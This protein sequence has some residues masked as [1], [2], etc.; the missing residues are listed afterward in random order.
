[1]SIQSIQKEQ[2]KTLALLLLGSD[3]LRYQLQLREKDLVRAKSSKE[4]LIYAVD[5]NVLLFFADYRFVKALDFSTLR[6]AP[7]ISKRLQNEI[8]QGL[9]PLNDYL[10]IYI[11]WKLTDSP[12]LIFPGPREEIISKS[13]YWQQ[14]YAHGNLNNILDNLRKKI[15]TKLKKQAEELGKQ[16]D[17]EH[18]G[19]EVENLVDWLRNAKLSLEQA[20]PHDVFEKLERLR[21]IF[22]QKRILNAIGSEIQLNN[23]NSYTIK[24]PSLDDPDQ[25]FDFTQVK[26]FRNRLRFWFDELAS[27]KFSKKP[28]VNLLNDAEM[29]ALLEWINSD[30]CKHNCR[31]VLLTT[32]NSMLTACS[33]Q[34][35]M[36]EQEENGFN[37]FAE[38]YLRHPLSL[39]ADPGAWPAQ[40]KESDVSYNKLK[41]LLLPGA[42]NHLLTEQRLLSSHRNYEPWKEHYEIAERIID[43]QLDEKIVVEEFFKEWGKLWRQADEAFAVENAMCLEEELKKTWDNALSKQT[44][45]SALLALVYEPVT[46]LVESMGTSYDLPLIEQHM[47]RQSAGRRSSRS[48]RGLPPISFDVATR[49]REAYCALISLPSERA[50]DLSDQE[51]RAIIREDSTFYTFCLYIAAALCVYNHLKRAFIFARQAVMIGDHLWREGRRYIGKSSAIS[52]V[53][54]DINGGEAYYFLAYITRLVA[55]KTSDLDRVEQLI[56][57]AEN[58]YEDLQISPGNARQKKVSL[59]DPRFQ[60]LRVSNNMSR[61]FFKIYVDK[62]TPNGDGELLKSKLKSLHND[63]QKLLKQ[64]GDYQES[65]L[66]EERIVRGDI[67]CNLLVLAIEQY[68]SDSENVIEHIHKWIDLLEDNLW[69][70]AKPELKEKEKSQYIQMVLK[71][72]K[73]LFGEDDIDIRKE[74]ETCYSKLD[75]KEMRV[76]PYDKERYKKYQKYI[77]SKRSQAD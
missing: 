20:M 70:E 14:N 40:L 5:S 10:G 65:K 53:H 23:E 42:G 26:K 36:D 30:F 62:N 11:F 32:D 73:V 7:F 22:E 72:A 6:R 61:L 24:K 13:N 55:R 34:P 67:L 41:Y 38:A 50:N 47:Q 57:Q 64:T 3:W 25:C 21:R 59:P 2:K 66:Y 69:P 48:P 68:S 71:I 18:A 16:K 37:S 29:L 8:Q 4:R 1:M 75:N 58:R 54:Q 17:S 63:L 76:F 27:E 44:F 9:V 35:Y 60:S 49:V 39:L 52:I 33:R 43:A 74:I 51:I 56:K 19:S 15:Q 77:L 12:L 31:L 28:D 46:E 45:A